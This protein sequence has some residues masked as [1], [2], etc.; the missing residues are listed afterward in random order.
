MS[1]DEAIKS[2]DA[3]NAYDLMSGE[4][5]FISDVQCMWSCGRRPLVS[6]VFATGFHA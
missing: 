6:M 3:R 2:I 1:I 5:K 4:A